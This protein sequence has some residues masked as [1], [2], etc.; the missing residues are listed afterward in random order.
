MVADGSGDGDRIGRRRV[1]ACAA[2][3]AQVRGLRLACGR[4]EIGLVWVE[5]CGFVGAAAAVGRGMGRRE[6]WVG[7]CLSGAQRLMC[8]RL[9]CVCGWLVA[10]CVCWRRDGAWSATWCVNWARRSAAD[11]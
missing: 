3:V 10:W 1:C 7:S 5:A 9:G 6:G 2:W 11:V 4:C 8:C